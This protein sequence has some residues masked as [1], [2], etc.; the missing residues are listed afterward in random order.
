M[1]SSN[2]HHDKVKKQFGQQANAYLTSKVHSQGEDLK[3]LAELLISYPLANL[4]DLGCGAGHVSFLAAG[5]VKSVTAYDLSDEMLDVVENTAKERGI[6]NIITQ[7]G[8]VEKLPFADNSFDIITSR[9][10]LHHWCDVGIAMREVKRVLRPGGKFFLIDVTSPGDPVL[11]V[12]LQTVEAL[13]DTS[14]VRDY[15]P[16]E[17]MTFITQSGLMIDKTYRYRL[18]LQFDS[19]VKR[20]RTPDVLIN[21]IRAYQ[22]SAGKETQQYFALQED[23]SFTSDTLLIGATRND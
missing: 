8:T 9:Y 7:Q 15:T 23:G 21:A 11:D 10:S 4:L 13:R 14:H 19:W 12:W 3:K 5:L 18:L 1:T 6:N 16:G 17:L 2:N 22:V 20:M